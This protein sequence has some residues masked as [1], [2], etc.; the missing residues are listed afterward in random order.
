MSPASVQRVCPYSF[1]RAAPSPRRRPGRFGSARQGP[2]ASRGRVFPTLF[3]QMRDQLERLRPAGLR[4]QGLE[5]R[6][7]FRSLDQGNHCRNRFHVRMDR[8]G[9]RWRR[10]DGLSSWRRRKLQWEL[11]DLARCYSAQARAGR[12]RERTFSA[13]VPRSRPCAFQPTQSPVRVPLEP[14]GASAVM[15][16]IRVATDLTG[17]GTAG[18][19]ADSSSIVGNRSA[20][21]ASASGCEISVC[22][23]CFDTSG[24]GAA[25]AATDAVSRS[26]GG[27]ADFGRASI[28]RLR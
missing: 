3:Q 2:S 26:C 14:L 18:V 24:S 7:T 16:S 6:R 25:G 8:H 22:F 13:R 15:A 1:W 20:T 23:G 5:P 27:G 17:S 19:L 12:P 10:S 4:Q 28:A 11:R 21:L 9:R